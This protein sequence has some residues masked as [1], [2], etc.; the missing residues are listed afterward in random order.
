MTRQRLKLDWTLET[1]HERKNFLD[2]YLDSPIFKITPPSPSELELM[3]NYVLWGRTFSGSNESIGSDLDLPSRNPRWNNTKPLDSLDELSERLDFNENSLHKLTDPTPPTLHKRQTFNR[4]TARRL[5]NFNPLLLSTLEDLWSRIDKLDLKINCYEVGIGQKKEIRKELQEK[6]PA[7]LI[8]QFYAEAAQLNNFTYLKLRH[9]LVEL[10][11]LQFTYKDFF[12]PRIGQASA[13]HVSPIEQDF[14]PTVYP[15]GTKGSQ[16]FTVSLFTYPVDPN[17]F[18]EEQL[19]QISRLYWDHY[20]ER[21]RALNEKLPGTFDFR[22]LDDVYQLF[23]LYVDL[24]DRELRLQELHS[25]DSFISELFDT[26]DFYLQLSD[27]SESQLRVLQLKVQ[28]KSNEEIR[29]IVNK[30]FNKSYTTNYISTIYRQKIIKKI[31]EAALFHEEI[32]S[33]LWFPEN[34]KKCT[35]CGE[36]LLLHPRNFVKKNKSKTGFNARCKK[37]DKLKRL[38]KKTRTE[39]KNDEKI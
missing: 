35:C 10:R 1:A 24:R 9:Q 38:E 34:F 23:Q 5:S 18:T 25:T 32:V 31:N 22:N 26:L 13:Y 39:E 3:A 21:S 2:T 19:A 4:E 29:D 17:S 14:E 36:I 30:E 6:F 16:D 15:F 8:Q 12:N 28:H 11:Q 20:D 7:S 37:C 27:L 33:N